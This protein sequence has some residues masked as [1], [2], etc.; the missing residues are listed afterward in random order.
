MES[1]LEP[2]FKQRLKHR[3]HFFE[4]GI[5][6]YLSVDV[7]AIGCCPGRTSR[8]LKVLHIPRQLYQKSQPDVFRLK[9]A[10]GRGAD[11]DRAVESRVGSDATSNC[12]LG[13]D[14]V[15]PIAAAVKTSA[16]DSDLREM[17]GMVLCKHIPSHTCASM[18]YRFLTNVRACAAT[19]TCDLK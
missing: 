11:A 8:D 12:A 7:E 9:P 16:V 14:C 1:Q 2:V 15:W 13:G 19:Y 5:A 3:P 18:T 4:A 6:R 17:G 10:G